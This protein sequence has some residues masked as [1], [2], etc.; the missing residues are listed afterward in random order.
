VKLSREKLISGEGPVARCAQDDIRLSV[1]K[2][3]SKEVK[4]RGRT[5]SGGRVA[6]N[7]QREESFKVSQNQQKNIHPG[8]LGSF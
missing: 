5:S 7:I 2:E 4:V 3:C 1:E 8:G 6:V